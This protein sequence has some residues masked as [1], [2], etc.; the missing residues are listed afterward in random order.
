MAFSLSRNVWSTNNL[1]FRG[2][3]NLTDCSTGAPK[4][5]NRLLLKRT[6][7]LL[8]FQDKNLNLLPASTIMLKVHNKGTVTMSIGWC[9]YRYSWL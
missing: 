2:I 7:T 5:R 8:E 6:E 3:F 1:V 9:L 4:K